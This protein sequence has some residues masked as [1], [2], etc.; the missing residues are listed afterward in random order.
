[1][2]RDGLRVKQ[3]RRFRRTTDS[4]HKD[5]IAPNVLKRNF[6]PKSPNQSW[7]P[8][9]TYVHTGEG[10]LY[11]AVMLDLF[12][13][14]VVGWAVSATNET[15]LALAALDRALNSRQPRPGLVHHSDR[16]S[17]YASAITDAHSLH[18]A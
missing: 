13:R 16:G 11:L 12:S 10:W 6:E 3:K 5:P 4:N 8:D 2:Q 7:A 17:P 14:R 1:M 18:A 15:V 9:V